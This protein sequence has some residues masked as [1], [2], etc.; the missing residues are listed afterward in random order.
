VGV[1]ATLP[2]ESRLTM[3]TICRDPSPHHVFCNPEFRGK[4]LIAS[5]A[6]QISR[7]TFR[8]NLIE[9]PRGASKVVSNS[10]ASV[11]TRGGS[12]FRSSPVK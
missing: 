5:F 3:V 11:Q 2:D 4:E 9:F 6:R 1:S 8:L 12:V 7:T 10:W